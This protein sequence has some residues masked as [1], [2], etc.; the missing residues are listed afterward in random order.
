[1]NLSP[2]LNA[3]ICCVMLVGAGIVF[4][5][6]H[7][8]HFQQLNDSSTRAA[9]SHARDSTLWE[10]LLAQSACGVRVTWDN[11]G[12]FEEAQLVQ[13]AAKPAQFLWDLRKHLAEKSLVF[14]LAVIHLQWRELSPKVVGV[15]GQHTAMATKILET[16]YSGQLKKAGDQ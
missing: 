2:R 7:F 15:R 10:R 11:W 5:I 6:S 14:Y 3:S 12:L 1:M 4:G 9:L 8:S 13:V 16:N